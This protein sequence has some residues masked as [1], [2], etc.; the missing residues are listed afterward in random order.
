MLKAPLPQKTQREL[1]PEGNHPARIY[2][3]IEIGTVDSTYAGETKKVHKIRIGFELPTEKRTFSEEKGEQPMVISKEMALSFGD[4]AGLRKIIEAVE[5]RKLTDAEAVDYDVETI[6]G[7]PLLVAVG[8]SEPNQEGIQY[9]NANTF[10]PVIKGLTVDPLYNKERLLTY[11]KWD[12]TLYQSLP[13]F[14]KEKIQSSLEFKNRGKFEM[15][16]VKVDTGE[17]KNTDSIPF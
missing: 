1:V 13:D 7:K 9:A 5:G 3:L 17:V 14:L 16:E 4:L 8:H 10:S 15:P 11:E 6:L 2:E 12:E